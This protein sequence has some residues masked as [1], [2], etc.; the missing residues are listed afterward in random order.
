MRLTLDLVP[1]S[2][3]VCRLPPSAALPASALEGTFVSV[4]R[5]HAELSVICEYD[6]APVDAKIEGPHSLLAVRGPLDF[7]LT[8]VLA[9]LANT[10]GD[11]NISIIAVSTYDTDYLLVRKADAHVAIAALRNAGYEVCDGRTPDY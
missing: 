2:F 6:R 1:G 9:R 10:L 5:T 4:T 3:A 11:A 8:G 7:A